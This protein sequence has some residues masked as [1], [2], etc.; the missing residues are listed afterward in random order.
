MMTDRFFFAQD[1]DSHWY[2]I[3]EA[4]RAVWEKMT[5]ND[6]DDDNEIAKFERT[7]GKYRT[8]GGINRYSF[9]DPKEN[10]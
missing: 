1:Q 5:V 10:P 6:L 9:T 2:L 8:G 7:F 4:K 3:P